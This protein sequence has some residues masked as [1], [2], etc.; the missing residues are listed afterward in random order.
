M[1]KNLLIE[2]IGRIH[3]IMGVNKNLLLEMTLP[4]WFTRIITR[5]VASDIPIL[6]DIAKK[7][8]GKAIPSLAN[9][10]DDE[11]R[12]LL[13]AERSL[14]SDIEHAALIRFKKNI[15]T[16][17]GS[18][19]GILS[20]QDFSKMT[21]NQIQTKLANA[22]VDPY[23]A[24]KFMT[25]YKK[26]YN[27][28]ERVLPTP[29]T[30][31][32]GAATGAVITSGKRSFDEMVQDLADKWGADV[33]QPFIDKL[34]SIGMSLK[35]KKLFVADEKYINMA[36]PDLMNEYLKLKK[37][38]TEDQLISFNRIVRFLGLDPD[39][40]AALTNRIIWVTVLILG[41]QVISCVRKVKLCILDLLSGAGDIVDGK[42]PETGGTQQGGGTPQGGGRTLG[43]GDY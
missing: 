6:K 27:V 31:G 14:L 40:P 22:G 24:G 41:A 42:K 23:Y 18:L 10:T 36:L 30:G 28:S 20:P 21:K 7:I 16:E 34:E 25:W 5:I 8:V 3:E 4:P 29:N 9:L 19:I 12:T 26:A 17:I 15:A 11:M 2:E 13:R 33:V 1:E 43:P 39:N 32:G 38:M 35:L 37:K